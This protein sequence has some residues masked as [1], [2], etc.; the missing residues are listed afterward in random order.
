MNIMK[1]SM[2]DLL[3][4]MS[5]CACLF[6]LLTQRYN[7]INENNSLS[8]ELKSISNVPRKVIVNTK[9]YTMENGKNKLIV[10]FTNEGVKVK[11]E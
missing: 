6:A 7:F 10:E 3:W 2:R 5:V 4:F 1:I 9:E 11:Q 8:R